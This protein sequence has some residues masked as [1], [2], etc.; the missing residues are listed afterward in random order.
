LEKRKVAIDDVN[1]DEVAR[2]CDGFSGAEIEQVVVSAQ[3]A[4]RAGDGEMNTRYLLDEI[5]ATRPLSVVMD[6]KITRLRQW[7]AHRTVPVD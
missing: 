5:A 3:Y 4:V 2:A 7:A 6:E 1:M